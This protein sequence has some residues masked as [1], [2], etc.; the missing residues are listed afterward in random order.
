MKISR[1]EVVVSLATT[2]ASNS[3]GSSGGGGG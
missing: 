1:G 2:D 3:P